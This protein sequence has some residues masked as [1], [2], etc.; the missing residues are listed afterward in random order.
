MKI[1]AHLINFE[2]MEVTDA[3][4]GGRLVLDLRLR[5]AGADGATGEAI[6]MRLSIMEWNPPLI[7]RE[8][9][10]GLARLLEIREA[11]ATEARLRIEKLKEEATGQ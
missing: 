7:T 10:K 5:R 4:D 2:L 6:T 3:T 9:R 11:R 8:F 1:N